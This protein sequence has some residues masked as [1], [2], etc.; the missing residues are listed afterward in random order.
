MASLAQALFLSDLDQAE[1]WIS[2]QYTLLGMPLA[3]KR[4]RLFVEQSPT[5]ELAL[6]LS[7]F[8]VRYPGDGTTLVVD[9]EPYRIH[10]FSGEQAYVALSAFLKTK[11]SNVEDTWYPVEGD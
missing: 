2:T 7:L 10:D 4:Y 3:K 11:D 9:T 1:A 5:E 8:R 6:R